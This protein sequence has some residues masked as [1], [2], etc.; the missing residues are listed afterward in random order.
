MRTAMTK[1]RRAM[2]AERQLGV[3]GQSKAAGATRTLD[4]VN[5]TV[6]ESVAETLDP[7]APEAGRIGDGEGGVELGVKD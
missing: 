3:G 2:G 5:E 4:K 7:R 1:N 6:H